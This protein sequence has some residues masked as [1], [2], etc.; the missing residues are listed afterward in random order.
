VLHQDI[1]NFHQARERAPFEAAAGAARYI[2][3]ILAGLE[4]ALINHMH[5]HFSSSES[6]GFKA[7][8]KF[9][10]ASDASFAASG[11]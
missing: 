1:N 10:E 4:R 9:Q 7:W 3:P 8:Y 5:G 2:P 11:N 6:R